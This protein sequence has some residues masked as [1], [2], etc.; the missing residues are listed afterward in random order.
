MTEPTTC[1]FCHLSAGRCY[2]C[3]SCKQGYCSLCHVAVLVDVSPMTLYGYGRAVETF[4]R[5]CQPCMQGKTEASIQQEIRERNHNYYFH[6][7]TWLERNH[8]RDCYREQ[9]RT[10]RPTTSRAPVGP[11]SWRK[12]ENPQE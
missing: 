8:Q 3:Y 6:S 5:Y 4:R 11:G 9:R 12:K 7:R 1:D 2:T 10:K